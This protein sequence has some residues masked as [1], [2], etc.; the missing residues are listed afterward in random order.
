MRRITAQGKAL[1]LSPPSGTRAES[2]RMASL[3]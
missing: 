2:L 3:R 1:S